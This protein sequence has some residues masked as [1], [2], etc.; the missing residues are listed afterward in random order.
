[1][2][3]K[4]L[5]YQYSYKIIF[6][7]RNRDIISTLPIQFTYL[8]IINFSNIKKIK[9]PKTTKWFLLFKNTF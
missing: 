8:S 1:M 9:Y 3:L 6:D 5:K 7:M 4:C 2:F